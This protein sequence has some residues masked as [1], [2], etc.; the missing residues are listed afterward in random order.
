MLWHNNILKYQFLSFLPNIEF[1]HLGLR[2]YL[3][4][5]SSREDTDHPLQSVKKIY[6]T[7]NT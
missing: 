4:S 3:S 2:V 6:M 5:K 7:H 1:V